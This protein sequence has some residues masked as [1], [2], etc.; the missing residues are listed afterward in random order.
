MSLPGR[1]GFISSSSGG[2][3]TSNQSLTLSAILCGT[4]TRFLRSFRPQ[5][6][7]REPVILRRP[8]G[9]DGTPG[10]GSAFLWKQVCK[11]PVTRD[12]L[13]LRVFLFP[14]P[15]FWLWWVGDPW[16]SEADWVCS[17]ECQLMSV[18]W[19]RPDLSLLLLPRPPNPPPSLCPFL[20]SPRKINRIV[21]RPVST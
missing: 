16:W 7:W 6:H 3:F 12:R 20:P 5:S 21:K 4:V 11:K 14:F 15:G 19:C 13:A 18:P 8:P 10:L 17:V 2:I 1:P 9:R